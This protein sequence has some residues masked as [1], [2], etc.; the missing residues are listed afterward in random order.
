MEESEHELSKAV[1]AFEELGDRWWMARSLL[2]LGEAQLDNGGGGAAA[3]P[4][5]AGQ[6]HLPAAGQRGRPAQDAGAAQTSGVLIS[7]P[8]A[9]LASWM[10]RSNS[11]RTCVAWSASS[12]M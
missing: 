7:S 3:P 4:L 9:C 5:T 2:Y 6:G 1:R 10:L 11:M 12:L 8:A